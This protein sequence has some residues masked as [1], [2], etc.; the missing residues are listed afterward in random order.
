MLLAAS[1]L[2]AIFLHKE[3]AGFNLRKLVRGP[4]ELGLGLG[5]IAMIAVPAVKRDETAEKF[6]ALPAI[7]GGRPI[8]SAYIQC[9]LVQACQD[10]LLSS[11]QRST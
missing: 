5:N 1:E 3:F 7:V 8:S 11:A 6:P 10:S 2:I 9:G 4:L